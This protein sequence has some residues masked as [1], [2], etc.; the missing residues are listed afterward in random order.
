MI[1]SLEYTITFPPS[2]IFPLGRRFERD[3]RFDAGMTAITGHNEA[4]KSLNLEFIRFMLFG[5]KALRGLAEDYKT[6]KGDLT[7]SVKGTDWLISRKGTTDAKLYRVP[8]TE[9]TVKG[10]KAVNLKVVE[11]LGYG[12]DVFD[13]GNAILQ[14]EAEKLGAMLPSERKKLV[15]ST[16]GLNIID[17]LIDWVGLQA[18]NANKEAAA[19]TAVNVVPVEP[20]RPVNYRPSAEIATERD[21]TY[22]LVRE[23]DNLR[24][25]FARPL[26]EPVT[27][28]WTGPDL[29]STA[30]KAKVEERQRVMMEISNLL[31]R[32]NAIPD[33][34]LTEDHLLHQEHLIQAKEAWDRR[35]SFLRT[36]P[37]PSMTREEI[38][39][40][41]ASLAH[42]AK[43]DE[44]EKLK[45][46]VEK[47]K[48]KG[49]HECPACHHTWD[50]EADMIADLEAQI[51]ALPS[52]RVPETYSK[53]ALAVE[54]AKLD[55]WERVADLW[56]PMRNITAP[57]ELPTMTAADVIR[58][59]LAL[60][61]AEEKVKLDEQITSLVA[62]PDVSDLYER[63]IK[64][65]LSMAGYETLMATY[66]AWKEEAMEKAVRIGELDAFDLDS[67]LHRLNV[68]FGE[69]VAYE[70]S[71]NAY[72]VA[73][74]AY[75]SVKADIEEKIAEAEDFKKAVAALRD[76][77][78]RVKQYI[79]P[80]LNRVAS[81]LL[82]QMTGGARSKI[83]IDEDFNISVDGQRLDTLSGSGKACANIAIRIGLGQVLTAKVFPVLL[84]DEID[85]AMDADRA[86][87][88][89]DALRG[90]QKHLGQI[91]LISHK[92]LEADH[93]IKLGEAA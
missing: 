93:Y 1:K 69:A 88:T 24:A 72:K 76:L 30:L 52:K 20:E 35:V 44:A 3:I 84:A 82:H 23:R 54:S 21:A 11:L 38:N 7:F 83:E 48:A 42:N 34:D 79:I 77:K 91:I 50:M 28:T 18:Q 85:A 10:T 65:E 75:N 60:E 32:R 31:A 53:A 27:P 78:V 29:D 15:D 73:L 81:H 5:S 74:A 92:K 80:S 58:H 41:G 8:E 33:T 47:L 55:A 43:V 87:F 13:A 25:F 12:L 68:E 71:L 62:P 6:F 57:L 90:L 56:E 14:G 45:A 2:N 17:G 9:P 4:G 86:G 63:R 67:K 89:A 26:A 46:K 59:R 66:L 51:A 19:M 36:Y 37:M 16:I 22:A 64:Y 49:Q 61:K 70:T 40:Y 39:E